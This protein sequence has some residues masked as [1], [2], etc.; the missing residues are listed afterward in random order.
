MKKDNNELL[1]DVA[2][3]IIVIAII[4]LIVAMTI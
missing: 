2:V 4:G 1:L 3:S